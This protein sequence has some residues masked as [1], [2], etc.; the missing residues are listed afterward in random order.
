[1]SD[2]KK[3]EESTTKSSPTDGNFALG[4]ILGLAI[5]L[6]LGALLC[7][8]SN[9]T[10]LSSTPPHGGGGKPLP[11][12]CPI[13]KPA[14]VVVG[15]YRESSSSCLWNAPDDL[16][17]SSWTI[18]ID[19]VNQST[20]TSGYAYVCVEPG[21]DYDVTVTRPA[22]NVLTAC[23]SP[24]QGTESNSGGVYTITRSVTVP[25]GSGGVVAKFG[26]D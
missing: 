23:T 3:K 6:A 8:R 1:M 11:L 7:C 10:R 14:A 24:S 17:L 19:G 20:D 21:A 26:M 2:E 25:S 9:D 12:S 18:T 5:A 16:A 4:F 22:N 15:V 13:E